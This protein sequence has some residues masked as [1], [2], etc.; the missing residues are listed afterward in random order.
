[1]IFFF[2]KIY[3]KAEHADAFIKGSLFAN[4]L[5]YFKQVENRDGR[6]DKFEGAIVPK[7]DGLCVKLSCTD[8][9]T[10]EATEI[11]I[12]PEDFAG[13][14]IILPRWFD[15][16]NLFCL[17]SGHS[18]GTGKISAANLQGLRKQLQMPEDCTRLGRYAVLIKNPKEFIRRVRFGAERENYR[19]CW[20]FVRYY[21]PEVGAAPLKSNLDSIFTKPKQ[22]EYQR[23]FRFAIDTGALG[24]DP[25][26]LDIGDIT[27][28]A[29]R[30]D[31]A[32]INRR[33]SLRVLR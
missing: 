9:Q 4:R 13:P 17:Y 18:G 7:L 10:G 27:D 22:F 31:T 33:L 8:T 21:D 32:D 1:M 24:R 14:P 19:I 25:I 11:T 2:A 6:G 12:P 29:F 16:F 23:E 3:E 26:T 20:R 15:H 30:M 5:C 28:I